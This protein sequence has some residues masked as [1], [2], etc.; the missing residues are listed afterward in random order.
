M[1]DN[2]AV[3]EGSGKNVRTT[4]I[5]GFQYQG[6][7]VHNPSTGTAIAPV[8]A[9]SAAKAASVP[10]DMA[11]DATLVPTAVAHGS[12]PTAIAAAAQANP[13]TNRAGIPFVIG[14]HPNSITRSH[15]IADSDG[16][17]TDAALITTGAGSKI[18]VTQ[19][20]AKMDATNSTNVAVK[21][22]FGTATIAAA[23]LAGTAGILLEGSF[24]AGG[25]HQVGNGAGILGVGADAEDLRITCGDPVSGNIRVTYTYYTIES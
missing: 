25:G 15:V 22:G 4:D 7:L 12:N 5:G 9:G 23:S 10:V 18:V 8:P 1:A 21:I 6:V 17:Q 11:T 24:S 20:S 3:T 13:K 19:I 2:V 14:G 16:A